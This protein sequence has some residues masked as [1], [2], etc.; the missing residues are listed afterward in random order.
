MKHLVSFPLEE[1]GSI[2]IEVDEPERE[3]TIRAARGDSIVKAKETLEEALHKVLPV[4]KSI[5]EK[6]HSMGGKPHEIEITFGIKLSTVAGAVI[7]SAS[8]EA[9][10]DITMRWSE[11]SPTSPP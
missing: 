9:N 10:F 4:T 2:V 8:A 3:G 7:A 5:V 11:Q 1:G 6:I